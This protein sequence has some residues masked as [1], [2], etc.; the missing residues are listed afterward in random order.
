M[1]DERIFNLIPE[2]LEAMFSR[3]NYERGVEVATL[4]KQC[5]EI[6]IEMAKEPL[7][8]AGYDIH[9]ARSISQEKEHIRAELTKRLEKMTAIVEYKNE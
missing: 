4:I 7:Q 8:A 3:E 1:R 9:S 5:V 6:V 2:V